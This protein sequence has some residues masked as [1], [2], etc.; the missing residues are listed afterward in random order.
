M[1]YL[2]DTDVFTLAYRDTHDLRDRID[3]ERVSN[4][5]AISL[6]TH[7]EVL[8]GRFDMV[9]KAADSAALIRAQQLLRSS[10]DYLA[11][12]RVLE[13]DAN[14]LAQFDRLRAIKKL[15]KLGRGDLLIACITLAYD[16]TLVTRNTKDFAPVTGLKVENWAGKS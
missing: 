12:F 14:A 1:I 16:A 4:E 15:K 3:T 5:V 7:I 2:L 6:V 13:F 10:R 9:L 11:T 8:R